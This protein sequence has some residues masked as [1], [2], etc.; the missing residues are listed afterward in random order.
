MNAFRQARAIG[1]ILVVGVNG[2][3][4]VEES[5]GLRPVLTDA[6][7]RARVG[8]RGGGGSALFRGADPLATRALLADGSRVAEARRP[9][10]R[11]CDAFRPDLRSAPSFPPTGR[12]ENLVALRCEFEALVGET[13]RRKCAS[14]NPGTVCEDG[15]PLLGSQ[16]L[17]LHCVWNAVL[18]RPSA[19]QCGFSFWSRRA[20]I[21]SV[22]FIGRLRPS[23]SKG[24]L[25]NSARASHLAQ[26]PLLLYEKTIGKLTAMA[27][28]LLPALHRASLEV[29]WEKARY[30]S[31]YRPSTIIVAGESSK[32]RRT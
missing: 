12:P 9:R 24:D 23:S 31:M 14:S 10:R 29:K 13:C 27:A 19:A 11:P 2:D 16:D 20:L 18:A 6:E 3:A 21:W 32:P 4:S 8:A 7:R 25:W 5:K 26:A 30:W 22:W 15:M 1:D 17:E 28:D